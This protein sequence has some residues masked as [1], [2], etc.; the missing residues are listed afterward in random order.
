MADPRRSGGARF[1]K[2]E[3][4]SQVW[5]CRR[6]YQC[7]RRLSRRCAGLHP[8]RLDD[9]RGKTLRAQVQVGLCQRS[10][11]SGRADR[12]SR[13]VQERDFEARQGR[14][15]LRSAQGFWRLLSLRAAQAGAALLSGVQKA[16]R[17]RGRRRARQDPRERVQRIENHAHAYAPVGL[18]P[19]YDVVRSATARSSRRTTSMAS[20]PRRNAPPQR[21][22]AQEHVWNEVWKRRILYFATVGAT[23]W[24]VIFPLVSSAQ[25]ADEYY[26]RLRWVSDL[27]R[28]IGGF[29]PK[30]AST[31]I[32]GYARAPFW[33]VVMVL[34]LTGLMAWSSTGRLAHSK[35]HEFDLAADTGCAPRAFPTI[36][37]I[38][39]AATG[40]I[41]ASMKGLK[42]RFAPLFFAVL[43]VYLG[44]SVGSHIS[45]DMSG[46]RGTDL[47]RPRQG[48]HRPA[49]D[50]AEGQRRPGSSRSTCP[51]SA[52]RPA[53]SSR[54]MARAIT[55][56]STNHAV[57]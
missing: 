9:H 56:R 53:S 54:P 38:G 29:L 39:C 16:R 24:L 4:L 48:P 18:P 47:H 35:S 31:W 43:F 28:F 57:G 21:A 22:E 6:A 5:F 55:S 1:I 25:R 27:V 20:R 42:H 10:A 8:V 50:Q 52:P 51:T 2:D 30:F 7:R 41:S 33:F 45:F 40:S 44:L 34:L 49:G 37:S 12:R 15:A 14:T 17:G 36:S 23:L 11:R 26:S 13:H 3:R 46:C 32:D 19:Y